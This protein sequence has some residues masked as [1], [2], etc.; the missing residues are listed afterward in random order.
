MKKAKELFHEFIQWSGDLGGWFRGQPCEW[1][2]IPAI[3]RLP[4]YSPVI[5]E[6]FLLQFKNCAAPFLSESYLSP[7]NDWEWLALAQHHGLPTRFLDLTS[8]PLV[9]CFFAIRKEPKEDGVVYNVRRSYVLSLGRIYRHHLLGE[10]IEAIGSNPITPI[11]LSES[12][13]TRIFQPPMF[14]RRIAAQS[15]YLMWTHNPKVNVEER[16][17]DRFVFPSNLKNGVLELLD[18][19]G[20]RYSSLFPGLDGLCSEIVMGLNWN[21]LHTW[22]KAMPK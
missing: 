12:K 15:S 14:S 10:A 20:I 17:I 3:G 5:E 18:R 2:L 22:N 9:A 16:L 13:K 1:P 6:D 8:N 21:A 7:A 11:S 4:G 19:M